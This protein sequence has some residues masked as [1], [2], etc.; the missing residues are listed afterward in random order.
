MFEWGAA[1]SHTQDGMSK[2][3][4][5]GTGVDWLVN[6][7]IETQKGFEEIPCDKRLQ[8]KLVSI[9]REIKKCITSLSANKNEVVNG[10]KKFCKGTDGAQA[11][12]NF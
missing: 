6:F 4:D 10:S 9:M 1:T 3:K 2:T 7:P 8:D 12:E 5:L 11:A